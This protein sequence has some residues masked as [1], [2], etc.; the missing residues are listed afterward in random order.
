MKEEIRRLHVELLKNDFLRYLDEF[1]RNCPFSPYQRDCH[2]AT[3]ACRRE[4]GTAA[5]AINDRTFLEKLRTTLKAWGV[6]SRGAVLVEYDKFAVSLKHYEKAISELD[7]LSIE[8]DDLNCD[9]IIPKLWEIIAG[10]DV[11]NN[12]RGEKAL[13]PIVSGTKTLHHILPDLV[14]PMDREYTQAF[15]GWHNPEFQYRQEQRFYYIFECMTEIAKAIKPS[16]FVGGGW[17]TCTA[18]LIDSALVGYCRANG[19]KKIA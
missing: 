18:K 19:I 6:G 13:A 7:G 14:P 12:L 4:L 17:R 3:I 15:F 1:D 11:V 9:L 2:I 5:A 10:L 8:A 16:Q